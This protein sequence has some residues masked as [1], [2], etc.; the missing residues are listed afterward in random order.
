MWVSCDMYSI[1]TNRNQPSFSRKGLWLLL[2]CIGGTIFS[3]TNLMG[4]L[5]ASKTHCYLC[6]DETGFSTWGL[7]VHKEDT[8]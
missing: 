8:K 1:T 3:A 5:K 7:G 4:N 6:W 2:L